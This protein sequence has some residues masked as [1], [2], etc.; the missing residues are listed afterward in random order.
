MNLC[1][2]ILILLFLRDPAAT[3]PPITIERAE[4]TSER[5][6]FDLKN[7]PSDMPKLHPG[8]AA[9]CQFNFNCAVKLKY[10]TVTE[11]AGPVAVAAH[12]RQIHVSL[13]LHNRIYLPRGAT[14][15]L[16]AHE[17]GHRIINE[18]VYE[19]AERAA[20]EAA[21]QVLTQTW[22]APGNDEPA[23]AKAATDQAVQKLCDL[24]LAG[25][26]GKAARVGEIYDDLTNHGRNLR[27]KESDAITQAFARYETEQREKASARE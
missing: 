12:I 7:L 5:I 22:R 17:E 23:A 15:K 2:S 24:Y 11:A 10:E 18:R 1:A 25:T 9:L 8:E 21:L 6:T 14:P 27:L 19:D 20:R 3:Q 16:R 26:A 13:T 4:P